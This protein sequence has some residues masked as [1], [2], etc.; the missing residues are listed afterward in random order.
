MVFYKNP[1]APGTRGLALIN[2]SSLWKG[3]PLKK[4]TVGLNKTGGRNNRGVITTRHIGGGVK[5]KMRLISF[6]PSVLL[7][8][9]NFLTCKVQRIEHDPCRSA[10]IALCETDNQKQF[11]IIAV[12]GLKAGDEIEMGF[13]NLS[14]NKGT[15][16]HL[17]HIANG[18]NVCCIESRFNGGMSIARSAGSFAVLVNKSERFALLKLSSGRKIEVPLNCFAMIGV[19]SNADHKNEVIAKAGRNRWKGTRPTVRG[20]V[21]NPVDHPHGGGE[22]KSKSGRHPCSPWGTLA[23]G[24]KTVRK[25]NKR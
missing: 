23:K 21:M 4:L 15:I 8:E 1:S 14:F 10:F 16:T 25:K 9:R 7:R 13:E 17:S 20:V 2:R 12:E 6:K 19:V 11:Y 3:K 24:K 22:G 5:R 18:A